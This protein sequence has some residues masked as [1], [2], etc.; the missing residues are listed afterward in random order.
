MR[1]LALHYLKSTLCDYHPRDLINYKLFMILMRALYD[2]IRRFKIVESCNF[3]ALL[4]RIAIIPSQS[5]YSSELKRQMQIWKYYCLVASYHSTRTHSFRPRSSNYLLR[6][7]V[8]L[9]LPLPNR[10]HHAARPG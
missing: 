8:L 1:N 10:K 9:S 3:N 6:L 5:S 7:R 2:A 4:F